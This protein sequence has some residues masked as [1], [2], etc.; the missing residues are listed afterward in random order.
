MFYRRF[1]VSISAFFL[2]AILSIEPAS[3]AVAHVENQPMLNPGISGIGTFESTNPLLASTGQSSP[4]SNGPQ[5]EA[6]CPITPPDALMITCQQDS[7]YLIYG[8]RSTFGGCY[9]FYIGPNSTLF[10]V[11]WC[12]ASET[13]FTWQEGSVPGWIFTTSHFGSGGGGDKYS[14]YLG[15]VTAQP[16][17]RYNYD[18]SHWGLCGPIKV[19]GD[20]VTVAEVTPGKVQFLTD[21]FSVNEADGQAQITVTR[22]GGWYGSVTVDYQSAGGTATPGEDYEAVSGTL[23]FAQGAREGYFYVDLYDDEIT[24]GGETVILTLDNPTNGAELGLPDTAVLTIADIPDLKVDA[25]TPKPTETYYSG[26]RYI[27]P[28]DVSVSNIGGGDPVTDIL[29][30]F[31][32]YG[33]DTNRIIPQLAPGESAVLRVEWNITSLLTAYKGK[34]DAALT[35][36]VDPNDVITEVRDDNNAYT[37]SAEVDARPAITK[38]EPDYFLGWFMQNVSVDNEIAVTVDWNGD[39]VGQGTPV[40][41]KVIYDLN[42]SQTTVAANG[43]TTV[44]HAYDMGIDLWLQKNYLNISAFSSQGFESD[45]S[46]HIIGQ[47]KVPNWLV[48][49]G[50]Q[51]SFEVERL[52]KPGPDLVLYNRTYKFPLSYLSGGVQAPQ[53]KTGPLSGKFG[54]KIPTWDLSFT[55]MSNGTGFITGIAGMWNELKDMQF[56][57]KGVG[58]ATYTYGGG[59]KG[60]V[61]VDKEDQLRLK[62]M[63]LVLRGTGRMAS[64]QWRLPAAPIV[65]LHVAGGL[66]LSAH[67]KFIEKTE[68]E[69]IKFSPD[70][71]LRLEPFV[72]AVA[73][74]GERGLAFA[75]AALG[76]KPRG[77]FQFFSEPFLKELL[78]R[79]YLR[80]SAGVLWFEQTQQWTWRWYLVGGGQ[81]QNQV[82]MLEP[83][84]GVAGWQ[85]ADRDYLTPSYATFTGDQP[86]SSEGINAII[87]GAYPYADPAAAYLGGGEVLSL[88]VHDNGGEAHQSLDLRASHWNG[89]TWGTVANVTND[90]IID[91]QPALAPTTGG[92]LAVW[93]RFKSQVASP[94][95]TEPSEVYDEMEIAYASYNASAKTWSAPLTLT[96]NTLMDFLP[97]A[98]GRNG[99][100][101]VLWLQDGDNDFPAFIDD[102][103]AFSEDIYYALWDG[104]TWAI[105]PTLAINDATTG[106]QP[107]FA[108]NGTSAVLVWSGD[109]DGD[110]N[111]VADRDI[112]Y[113]TWNGTTWTGATRFT[114]DSLADLS[115]RVTYDSTGTAHL[116]WVKGMPSGD[117]FASQLYYAALNGSWSAPTQIFE[118]PDL[119]GLVLTNAWE[120]GQDDLAAIWRGASD[121]P[122]DLYHT[123]YDFDDASWSQPSL[124]TDDREAEW[125]Y[126]AVWDAANDQVFLVLVQREVGSEVVN[127]DFPTLAPETGPAITAPLTETIAITIPVFG[128]SNLGW[129]THAPAPDL[130]ITAADI[131]LNPANPLPGASAIIS[132]TIQNLGDLA[133][134]PVKVA[135]YDGDPDSGGSL[136]DSVT[137]PG[138]LTGRMTA[139][140]TVSWNVPGT[141]TS[142]NI[143][144]VVD[145]NDDVSTESDEGNNKA[146]V[147]TVQQ[148]LVVDWAYTLWSTHTLTITAQVR[149]TGGSPT[150]GNFEVALRADDPFTGTVLAEQTVNTVLAYDGAETV[151]FTIHN[152]TSVISG[153]HLGFVFADSGEDLTEADE[154]NNFSFTSLA[155][156]ADLSLTPADIQGDGV[157]SLV[158]HNLGLVDAADVRVELRQDTPDGTLLDSGTIPSVSADDSTTLTGLSVP[159]GHT[160]YVIID[161]DG[162][163]PEM[164]ESNNAAV[165]FIDRKLYLPV[166]LR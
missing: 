117:D 35:A 119:S 25:F 62:D 52:S 23:T 63:W 138:S 67:I 125:S 58:S 131:V 72:E 142:H 16:Y 80:L 113:A 43:G 144:V 124:L 57:G 135:F 156:L 13:C 132:A 30:N 106:E 73:L 68:T 47:T 122:S 97:N 4:V 161:P 153:A 46:T 44:S 79:I 152:P 96:N 10:N 2:F 111:T 157:L 28:V 66:D 123:V 36:I 93:T 48:I 160:L 103:T 146:F 7:Y 91:F 100:V 85:P 34:A 133:A 148:D 120:N 54:P 84:D 112:Y 99:S 55:S 3:S 71:L 88:W 83:A 92:A 8:G 12:G 139:T 76:A 150:S 163:I 61:Q 11:I 26:G 18:C 65:A 128:D 137:L 105:S 151:V 22:T 89:T 164:D 45:K 24:E 20:S 118:V 130:A 154:D 101:M 162:D 38:V 42:G 127:V 60:V 19:C 155:V 147:T 110:P 77:D 158:V 59:L 95:P 86:A 27:L 29:V 21:S 94:A 69:E 90:T 37:G 14:M 56:R 6:I 166:V 109:T 98:A 31:K 49:P 126:D 145:P 53:D 102:D 136:I 82:L 17:G 75:E 134:N 108:Y 70:F 64:P 32:G 165:I 140:L 9:W 39:V 1:I 114:N 15:P 41:D 121:Q 116:L 81:A 87:T 129:L 115:P 104:A 74:A 51:T 141:A 50:H 33:L 5:Q 149:N 107:Q 143:Y 159:G 40:A 78:F